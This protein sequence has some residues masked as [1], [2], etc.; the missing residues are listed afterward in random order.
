MLS[1]LGFHCLCSALQKKSEEFVERQKSGFLAWPAMQRHETVTV[2]YAKCARDSNPSHRISHVKFTTVEAVGRL[3]RLFRS[4]FLVALL[5]EVATAQQPPKDLP[6]QLS[7][8]DAVRIALS[9]SSVIRTAQARLEQVSG[10]TAQSRSSLLP[11]VDFHA[12]QAYLTINLLGL[13]IDIPSVPQGKSA[14]FGSMDARVT[15]SQ[16]LLNI[17]NRESWKSSKSQ[18]TSYS[19]QVENARETVVLDVVATYLLALR[20]K[21]TRDTLLEQRKLANDLFGLTEDRVKQG[22]SAPLESIRESQQVNSLQQQEQEAEQSFVEAKLTLANLLQT[23]ISSDFDVSDTTAYGAQTEVDRESAI[24]TAL[25]SRPDYR[26]REASIRA[27]RLQVRSIQAYRLPTVTT[28]FS[29]GQ[30][31]ET[32]VHNVNTYRLQGE[33][34]VPLFTSGRI[35]GQID[36][37]RGALREEQSGLDQLRSQIQTE[38]MT[39]IA[40]VEW[41]LKEVETSASN[42]TLSRQEVDLTRQR[43][44]RGVSDNT[45]VVNAQ[46]RVSRADDARVRAM[47]TLGLARA[48]LA[49]AIGAA[50]KTYRK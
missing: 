47:F 9:N 19:L 34:N 28:S 5:V 1:V 26:S 3:A 6:K 31:G 10:R 22:V 49:R 29:D 39:A 42:V 37:A 16:D 35:R 21:A 43:F 48:N 18:Q 23:Q 11:Q 38:V 32:P 4:L 17:A 30:S 50:E 8:S 2:R 15:L 13:G 20:A 25:A 41:A 27:A 36:E 45:E 40:G 44:T 24:R 14:P 12:R 46:D 7:L 33:I